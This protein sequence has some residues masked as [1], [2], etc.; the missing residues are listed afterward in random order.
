M[1]E[2]QSQK[3]G[4]PRDF[5]RLWAGQ[6]VSEF[7][8]QLT[9]L[10]LPTLAILTLSA[11]TFE[12]G[13][14]VTMENLATPLIGLL[15]GVFIDRVRRRGVLIVADIGRML[16]LL[17]VVILHLTGTLR[18]EHLYITAGLIGAFTVFFT[19]AYHAY[20]P[21]LV[22][23]DQVMR[24]N[25]RLEITS[26][27][28]LLAGPGAGGL[29]ISQI[30]SAATI[31]LDAISFGVSALFTGLIRRREPRPDPSTQTTSIRQDIRE[32]ARY[33]WSTPV[34]R[35]LT[36]TSSLGNLGFS[37]VLAILAVF[38]YRTLDL[39]PAVFGIVLTVSSAG[40]LI[41]AFAAGGSARKFGAGKSLLLANSMFA[42]GLLAT[43]LAQ[44]GAPVA[45]LL[46]AQFLVNLSLPWYNIT[47]HS[48][49][50]VW[51]PDHMLGRVNATMRTVVWGATPVGAFLGGVLGQTLGVT[52]TI[53]IGG[54]IALGS[55]IA[56]MPSQI[57]AIRDIEPPPGIGSP[58][59]TSEEQ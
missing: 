32:G 20:V 12:V 13:L 10:A 45:V 14:I 54:L 11:S 42:V 23:R 43:P 47:S 18:L 31:A 40:F 57:R 33:V 17:A 21:F 36:I 27:G 7:G 51:T 6:A 56:L 29:L 3:R 59:V 50:Q 2:T 39:S 1:V 52:W 28:A 53:T 22:G 8:T 4:L 25:T 19:V 37:M 24:A 38:A 30:G 15:V 5:G 49:Q 44:F 26:S 34:L 16:V 41:S 58:V 46:A 35:A 48:L 55:N 9:A